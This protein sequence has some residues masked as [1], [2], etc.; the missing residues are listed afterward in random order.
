MVASRSEIFNSG[1]SEHD[2]EVLSNPYLDLE[3]S[4]NGLIG[5]SVGCLAGCRLFLFGG[6][7]IFLYRWMLSQLIN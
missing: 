3:I 5:W 1:P 6:L 2:A 4:W 7:V